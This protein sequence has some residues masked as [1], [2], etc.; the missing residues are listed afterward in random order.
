MPKKTKL[1]DRRRKLDRKKFKPIEFVTASMTI[2]A[3]AFT[4]DK[5]IEIDPAYDGGPL[6]LD[7]FDAFL[8]VDLSTLV[9]QQG[10][11]GQAPIL[12]EHQSKDTLGHGTPVITPKSIKVIDGRLSMPG[13][14]RDRV[15][16]ASQNGM[17]LQ[18]SI[19]AKLTEP[20]KFI[21]AGQRIKVNGRTV[22]GPA[23]VAHNTVLR[24]VSVTPL[25]RSITGTMCHIAASAAEGGPPMGFNAW[26]ESLGLDRETLSEDAL[27][28]LQETYSAANPDAAGKDD[29]GNGDETVQAG[30]EEGAGDGGGET[31]T[32][33]R[34]S[35]SRAGFNRQSIIDDATRTAREAALAESRRISSVNTIAASY[36]NVPEETRQPLTERALNGEIGL[37]AF[38]RD[39]LLASRSIPQSSGTGTVNVSRGFS[40]PLAI[41]AALLQ[42]QGQMDQD[43]IQAS[44]SRDNSS[45]EVQQA[46]DM[47]TSSQM[48]NLR[49]SDLCFAT[50]DAAGMTPPSRHFDESVLDAAMAIRASAASTIDMPTALESTVVRVIQEEYRVGMSIV[51]KIAGTTESPDIRTNEAV[52]VTSSGTLEPVGVD[53]EVTS[54]SLGEEVTSYRPKE[55]AKL[56]HVSNQLM[57]AQGLDPMFTMGRVF[58][59]ASATA[60]TTAVIK[61]LTH[62][63][64]SSGSGGANTF[65]RRQ[66]YKNW[67]QNALQGTTDVPTGVTDSGLITATE[68]IESQ[69]S[70]SGESIML[71]PNVLL[72]TPRWHSR[73]RAFYVSENITLGGETQGV[74]PETNIHRGLYE[75]VSSPHLAQVGNHP[76]GANA[77]KIKDHWFLI[78]KEGEDIAPVLVGYVQGQGRAPHI[79]QFEVA[80]RLGITIRAELVFV[81]VPHDRRTV[82]R[83]DNP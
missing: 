28:S 67:Q 15:V 49:L 34:A 58:A 56:M 47:A 39:L 9:N 25:G 8:Y 55:H 18:A 65:F 75:P 59:R 57:L 72:C 27:S 68:L 35:G 74:T 66:K 52:R 43:Q 38:E 24:E 81:A 79:R 31:V 83:V 21:S 71:T 10:D 29:C 3:G 54:M 19:G 82:V 48:R 40:N 23:Y 62:A 33:S 73:A 6:D 76:A 36:S 37:D 4:L 64:Y 78:A 30:A 20:A 45:T 12:Y 1:I 16:E 63:T 61:A 5:P 51:D 13:E 11:G 77:D 22:R 2:A 44:M 50:I 69:T 70:A 14:A 41:Q 26:L 53:G 42:S 80:T 17:E 7:Q 32:A 46:L 60:V